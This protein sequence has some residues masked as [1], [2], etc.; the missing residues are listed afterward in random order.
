MYQQ[1]IRNQ[2]QAGSKVLSNW[3][4]ISTRFAQFLSIFQLKQRLPLKDF[5]KSNSKI[6][7]ALRSQRLWDRLSKLH[8]LAGQFWSPALPSP[9][10]LC[11][12]R[13]LLSHPACKAMGDVALPSKKDAFALTSCKGKQKP[14]WLKFKFDA[15]KRAQVLIVDHVDL[16]CLGPKIGWDTQ[17]FHFHVQHYACP[18]RATPRKSC[19]CVRQVFMWNILKYCEINDAGKIHATKFAKQ[20]NSGA[21]RDKDGI[22][23]GDGETQF[24]WSFSNS[25]TT[26]KGVAAIPSYYAFFLVGIPHP[27]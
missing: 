11:T 23:G 18:S 20:W 19:T 13:L 9:K 12:L 5:R 26:T 25:E 4:V 7:F 1:P 3:A 24:S 22:T 27:L 8:A 14:F 17:H 10:F 2:S 6:T 21:V 15:T 16:W